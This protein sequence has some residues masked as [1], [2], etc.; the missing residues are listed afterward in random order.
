MNVN[1]KNEL[2]HEYD[3]DDPAIRNI[4]KEINPEENIDIHGYMNRISELLESIES[5]KI[6]GLINFLIYGMILNE[7][8]GMESLKSIHEDI[9]NAMEVYHSTLDDIEDTLRRDK[10]IKPDSFSALVNELRMDKDFYKTHKK[11]INAL[12][13]ML[14]DIKYNLELISR[15]LLGM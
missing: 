1:E 5:K 10:T 12:L 11:D 13:S 3:V 4:M 14:P 2:I 15:V 9:Q 7:G 8:E 6:N